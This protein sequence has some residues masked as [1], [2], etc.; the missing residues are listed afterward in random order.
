MAKNIECAF[1]DGYLYVS[2]R[3]ADTISRFKVLGEKIEL[4]ENT[5]CGGASPRD[6]DIIDG[7]IFCA[8]ESTNNVTVML[9]ENGKPVLTE[10]SININNPICIT[11]G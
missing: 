8:N 6:F 9:L 4:L 1:K 10:T 7:Y 11:G 2:N 3:G 5:Y